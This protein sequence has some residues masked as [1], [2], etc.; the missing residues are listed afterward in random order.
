MKR[1][2][3]CHFTFEDRFQ[4]C[5]FDGSELTSF[6]DPAPLSDRIVGPS[7]KSNLI[8]FA[9]SRIG[10]AGLVLLLLVPGVVLIVRHKSSSPPTSDEKAWTAE[11]HDSIV[12]TAPTRKP[13]RFR[14]R[15][16]YAHKPVRRIRVTMARMST[17][18]RIFIPTR[19]TA[20]VR[21]SAPAFSKQT[22]VL[23]E[24]KDSKLSVAFK[25]T[26]NALKKT[27]GFLKKPFTSD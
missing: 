19:T 6:A 23:S 17:P 5:D 26:G 8:R 1:C 10:L 13:R 25:K 24:K 12:S 27:L 7:T 9:H 11:R 22:A 21:S 15:I 2:P 4:V 14:R 18:R 16:A 3:E 20:R